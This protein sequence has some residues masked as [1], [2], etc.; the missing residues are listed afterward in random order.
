MKR[1]VSIAFVASVLPAVAQQQ[2]PPS[3]PTQPLS[4][5]TGEQ[6]RPGPA[7]YEKAVQILQ[8]ASSPDV[9]HPA[10]QKK[11][12]TPRLSRA[13][14]YRRRHRAAPRDSPIAECASRVASV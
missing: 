8:G 4:Q 11:S 6:Q 5:Q 12:D 14:P 10:R 7:E 2:P 13:T 3:Q 1:Y 9:S